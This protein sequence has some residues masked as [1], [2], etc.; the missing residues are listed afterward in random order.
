MRYA[1]HDHV[2]LSNKKKTAATLAQKWAQ[3]EAHQTGSVE[4][5]P[6]MSQLI[7]IHPNCRWANHFKSQIIFASLMARTKPRDNF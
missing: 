5:L 6:R 3:N 4:I 1:Q 2:E 7:I